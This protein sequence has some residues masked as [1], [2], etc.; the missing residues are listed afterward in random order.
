MKIGNVSEKSGE[1]GGSYYDVDDVDR[2]GFGLGATGRL[3]LMAK[4]AE[5]TGM[6]IPPAAACVLNA[7]LVN[8]MN[9]VAAPPIATQCFMLS[10]LFDPTRLVAASNSYIGCH[11]TVRQK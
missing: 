4:L 10:N 7:P 2:A 5:G 3:Q 8:P 6:Q 11:L 1:N 9:S